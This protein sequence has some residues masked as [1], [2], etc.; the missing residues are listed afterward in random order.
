VDSLK[1]VHSRTRR[2]FHRVLKPGGYLLAAVKAGPG[3]GYVHEL[4]GIPAEIYLSLFDG[5]EIEGY[6]ERAGFVVEFL[7]RRNPYDFEIKNERI[8]AI[9]R[10]RRPDE[11]E[12]AEAPGLLRAIRYPAVLR[13]HM[14]FHGG[15][16]I[17]E[18][19]LPDG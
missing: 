14:D 10:K 3:E 15:R 5:A 13:V 8:F 1:V 11:K 4:L 12:R 16:L 17:L 7:E 6:F 18:K 2:A 9:G 19:R